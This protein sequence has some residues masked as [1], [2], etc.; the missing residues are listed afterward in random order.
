MR[1]GKSSQRLTVSKLCRCFNTSKICSCTMSLR[2]HSHHT[3]E[4]RQSSASC[5]SCHRVGTVRQRLSKPR[6]N[7]LSCR[8]IV[9]EGSD[10]PGDGPFVWAGTLLRVH[11]L[12]QRHLPS[13]VC[14]KPRAP[15]APALPWWCNQVHMVPVIVTL[16]ALVPICKFVLP[17]H[18]TDPRMFAAV[19]RH[20]KS[21]LRSVTVDRRGRRSTH[22]IISRG[23]ALAYDTL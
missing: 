2:V 10:G 5:V 9:L 14:S 6:A 13:N 20:R 12:D 19:H 16:T 15:P 3:R 18:V 11:P 23:K 22:S 7:A 8:A 17:I 1:K 4:R 21:A